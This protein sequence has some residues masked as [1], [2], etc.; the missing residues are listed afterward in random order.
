M[1]RVLEVEDDDN[2]WA[3]NGRGFRTT[4]K[5]EVCD[6]LVP[7]L[8]AL[9]DGEIPDDVNLP[10]SAA[11]SRFPVGTSG[12]CMERLFR[13]PD[14]NGTDAPVR[15]DEWDPSLELSVVAGLG[16]SLERRLRSSYTAGKLY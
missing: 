15:L 2:G 14:T 11:C 5:D 8:L 16:P 1:T 13:R 6:A 10:S 7:A 3:D 12:P 4:A 9:L